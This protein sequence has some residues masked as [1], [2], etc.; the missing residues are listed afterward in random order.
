MDEERLEGEPKLGLCCSGGPWCV[1][2]PRLGLAENDKPKD[3]AR[4]PGPPH[5][6]C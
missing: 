5:L 4:R 6:K 2:S 3:N 1:S